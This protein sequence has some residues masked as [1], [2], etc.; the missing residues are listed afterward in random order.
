MVKK[1]P[2]KPPLGFKPKCKIPVLKSETISGQAVSLLFFLP[3][4]FQINYWL[5]GKV[6]GPPRFSR[7]RPLCYLMFLYLFYNLTSLVIT[8]KLPCQVTAV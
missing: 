8:F 1:L 2:K 4:A 3:V 7:G 5:A 6:K